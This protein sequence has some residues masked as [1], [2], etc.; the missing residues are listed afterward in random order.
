MVKIRN[1]LSLALAVALL[2]SLC[3]CGQSAG[4]ASANPNPG[5]TTPP[6]T[7][8]VSAVP[9]PTDPEPTDPEPTPTPINIDI[10]WTEVTYSIK[11]YSGY[12][13]DITL[14]LS[15]WILLSDTELINSAWDKV[16]G[17]KTLPQF[18]DWG[19]TRSGNGYKNTLAYYSYYSTGN[20]G[21]LTWYM[22][23]MYY[24]VGTVTIKNTTSG[25][26]I[27]QNDP[28]TVPFL[29]GCDAS[30]ANSAGYWQ[31]IAGRVL[32]SNDVVTRMSGLHVSASVTSNT[33]GPVPVIF[34]TPE[35]ISP[36]SPDGLSQDILSDNLV[37]DWSYHMATLESENTKVHLGI[38]KG[39]GEY[40]TG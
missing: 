31:W 25:F 15:P 9:A 14:K 22:T 12:T 6:S 21:A 26:D 18:D 8:P 30:L 38:L 2:S 35:Y 33:W 32:Y 11:D 24:S 19:F 37:F 10:P 23:D 13:F 7:T 16:G 40:I 17:G 3:A 36:N 4:T 5:L 28:R 34:M 1:L 20:A 39:D 29:F 27:T